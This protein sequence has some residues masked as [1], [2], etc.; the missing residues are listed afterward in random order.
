MKSRPLI[1]LAATAAAAIALTGCTGTSGPD[2]AGSGGAV[3]GTGKTLSVMVAAN[4]LYPEQQKEWFQQVSDAFE[5]KTGAKVEFETFASANDELT[6]IQ[7]SVL[8]GQGPD[9]YG[10]GTTFTPTAYA[11]GAFVKLTEAD[12]DKVGGRDR[13]VPSTLGISGPSDEDEIAIPFVSRPFVMAYNTELLKAAGIDEVPTTWDELTAA[14]AKIDSGDVQ[15]LAIGYA[16]SFDPWK[17]IWGMSV[18]AG[19]PLIDVD[20]KK[21]KIDDPTVAAAYDTYFGWFQDGLVD[22]A[23]VG[24]KNAQ[25]VAAFAEGKAG[26]LPMTAA[27]SKPTFAESPVA[28]SY[29]YA[30]LP[31]VPPGAT[32]R[33]KD[34]KDAASILS[35]DNLVVAQYSP[36]QDLAFALIEMLTSTESQ[37]D[38]F[39]T[40]GELPTGVDAAAQVEK[41]NP[42]LSANVQAASKSVATPFTGAWGDTQLALTN[43]VVQSLPSL[44]A[45][46]LSEGDIASAIAEAQASS[47]SS[48]DKSK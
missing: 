14:A 5:K 13:F 15:G 38:Y 45:G 43:V 18:Q 48:L 3:D 7:T 10:L 2:D 47:Q 39:D 31:T 1:A 6:K 46:S 25:A 12:W 32:E 33:P 16:D 8:S 4:G 34:G 20:A 23:S 26:F 27:V 40:F 24:W 28:D 29:A 19:N 44:Q 37:I 11:T 9:V 36:N 21:A 35:G 42:D 22:P 41:D 30:L 17:F